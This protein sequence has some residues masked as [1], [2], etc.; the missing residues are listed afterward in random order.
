MEPTWMIHYVN[1][2]ACEVCNDPTCPD[3]YYKESFANIHTHGLDRYNQRELCVCIDIGFET[4]G[5][6]LNS[7]GKRVA[8][9]ETVFTEGIR[10]DILQGHYDVQLITFPND[11]TLYIILPDVNGKF[12]MDKDCEAPFCYQEEYAKILSD[13]KEY[14]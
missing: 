10:S 1:S 6:L 12:P 9:G 13:N 8:E 11:P 4:A 14:V 5:N 7:M 2:A 3:Y